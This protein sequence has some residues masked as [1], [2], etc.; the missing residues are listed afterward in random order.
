MKLLQSSKLSLPGSQYSDLRTLQTPVSHSGRWI[1][2]YCSNGSLPFG[3][4][5]YIANNKMMRCLLCTE[6]IS[7]KNIRHHNLFP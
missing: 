1:T 2:V 4:D 3:N 6:V 5:S 7:S